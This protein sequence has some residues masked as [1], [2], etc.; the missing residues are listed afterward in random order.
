MDKAHR[1]FFEAYPHGPWPCHFCG[2]P[3]NRTGRFKDD[4]NLHHIDENHDHNTL[5]NLAMSHAGCHR[6]YH[7]SRQVWTPERRRAHSERFMGHEVP[8]ETRSK[9]S[10]AN[11]GG[12]GGSGFSG[13]KHTAESRAKMSATRR[14]A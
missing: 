1:I 11:R 8:E 5:E 10:V 4:G 12:T 13:H 3:V 7:S 14:S 6:S 9:I 2:R